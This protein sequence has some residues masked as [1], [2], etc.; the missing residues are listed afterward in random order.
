MQR[1]MLMVVALMLLFCQEGCG[2]K[3]HCEPPLYYPTAPTL[4]AEMLRRWEEKIGK[5]PRDCRQP[6]MWQA[7]NDVDLADICGPKAGGCMR[8]CPSYWG[9]KRMGGGYIRTKY[10]GDLG[11]QAHETAHWFLKCSG[12]DPDVN[13]VRVDIWHGGGFVESF[14]AEQ[15]GPIG[16]PAPLPEAGTELLMDETKPTIREPIKPPAETIKPSAETKGP[17]SRLFQM[18]WFRSDAPARMRL[19]FA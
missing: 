15:K 8:E 12:K 18:R 16:P 4:H 11:L 7:R 13:H 5:V 10:V 3:P 1:L 17:L 14:R 9:E 2:G 6:M 19:A